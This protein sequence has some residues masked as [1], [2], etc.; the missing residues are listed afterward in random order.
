MRPPD[1]HCK[2]WNARARSRQLL[3]TVVR[4]GKPAMTGGRTGNRCRYFRMIVVFKGFSVGG[5]WFTFRFSCTS[6]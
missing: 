6:V 5:I 3:K 4:S 1:F 2:L